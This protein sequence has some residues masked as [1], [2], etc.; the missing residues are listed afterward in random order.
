MSLCDNGDKWSV[1]RARHG[2]R[3]IEQT[4]RDTRTAATTAVP[5]SSAGRHRHS[6]GPRT[7]P[8]S[9]RP[10][11][12]G[13]YGLAPCQIA[14][15]PDRFSGQSCGCDDGLG[16]HHG[17]TSAGILRVHH[18]SWRRTADAGDRLSGICAGLRRSLCRGSPGTYL[19][20]RSLLA[21]R[22]LRTAAAGNRMAADLAVATAL[23]RSAR[24]LAPF[25]AF[26]VAF[27]LARR[28]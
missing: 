17:R 7:P 22:A 25:A 3:Q 5:Q 1:D 6:R 13:H 27:A 24:P 10:Q 4:G 8:R 16:D 28:A 14:F 2:G 9:G 21:R 19:L 23:V 12:I 20:Q 18:C 11:E 15:R 26:L